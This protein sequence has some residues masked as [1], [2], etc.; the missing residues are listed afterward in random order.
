MHKNNI[1][2]YIAPEIN[3]EEIVTIGVV[4]SSSQSFGAEGQAGD[5]IIESESFIL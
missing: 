5:E 2:D 1:G 3:V 4:A